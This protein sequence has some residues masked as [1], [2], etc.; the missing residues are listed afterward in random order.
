MKSGTKFVTH[1]NIN[2]L[3]WLSGSRIKSLL[4]LFSYQP[5]E[6]AEIE[7]LRPSLAKKSNDS[8]ALLRSLSK[9]SPIQCRHTP[10]LPKSNT[11]HH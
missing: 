9:A 6:P 11:S 5:V 7:I 1:N 8:L 4:L 2:P 10:S 3:C